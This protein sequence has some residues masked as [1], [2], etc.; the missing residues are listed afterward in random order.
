MRRMFVPS[1]RSARD[2]TVYDEATQYYGLPESDSDSDS[3]CRPRQSRPKVPAP[4]TLEVSTGAASEVEKEAS[5]SIEK[6][7]KKV[8]SPLSSNKFVRFSAHR[9][10]T[11]EA[12]R[13]QQAAWRAPALRLPFP[14]LAL[15]F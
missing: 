3:E 2:C 12:P 13:S 5:R 15:K 1:E 4:D 7:A 10:H 14:A 11:P 6:P 9:Q 8:C